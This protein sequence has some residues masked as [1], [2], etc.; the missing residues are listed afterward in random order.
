MSNQTELSS[1]VSSDSTLPLFADVERIVIA[2]S[3]VAIGVLIT[4]VCFLLFRFIQNH[5]NRRSTEE[6]L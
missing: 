6:L 4:C 5:K 1:G 2:V 3:G